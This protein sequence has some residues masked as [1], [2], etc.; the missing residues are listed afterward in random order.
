MKNKN[1]MKIP[2]NNYLVAGFMFFGLLACNNQTDSGTAAIEIQ[3]IET[4]P[5]INTEVL[6]PLPTEPASTSQSANSLSKPVVSPSSSPVF[7]SQGAV[8]PVPQKA[9]EPVKQPVATTS[10]PVIAKVAKGI[11]PAHGQPGHDCSV[12]VGAPLKSKA[13]VAAATPVKVALPSPKAV[14]TAP[15]LA[16]APNFAPNLNP[17]AKV[18]PAHGQPGHDCKIAVGAPLPG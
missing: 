3:N 11:N 13:T 5:S 10:S 16:P 7:N 8:Q 17:N 18:N 15:A 12:A 9:S 14:E 1:N 4:T 2:K 6:P